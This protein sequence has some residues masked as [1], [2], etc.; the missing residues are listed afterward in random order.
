MVC[1]LV[2]TTFSPEQFTILKDTFKNTLYPQ[3]ASVV[4]L[5]SATHLDELTI[6]TWFE[7]QHIKR[8]NQQLQTWPSLAVE[9][10]NQVTS[11]KEEKTLYP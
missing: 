8:R 5:T 2:H 7:N 9:A 10:P 11:V 1:L 6:K 4:G 3:W